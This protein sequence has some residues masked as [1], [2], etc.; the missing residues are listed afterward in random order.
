MVLIKE[1]APQEFP[2]P[3]ARTK[4]SDPM[5]TT[6]SSAFTAQPSTSGAKIRC[7]RHEG[8]ECPRCDGSGF[9]PVKRCAGCGEPAGS[10]SVG[11]GFP[12]VRS[13]E[14]GLMYHVRCLPGTRELDAVWSGLE[15]MEDGDCV[16]SEGATATEEAHCYQEDLCL[17]PE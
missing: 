13:H 2:L 5:A 4:G 3:E 17:R 12:L 1:M 8:E 15:R 6:E 7:F 11:P 14:D 10:I 16:L 9:R